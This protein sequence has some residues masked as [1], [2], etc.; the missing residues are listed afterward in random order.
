MPS[1]LD[2]PT[3]S[4]LVRAMWA[5]IR[6]V[7]VLPLVPVT[8]TTGIRGVIVVGRAPGSA[9]A[10]SAAAA[11]TAASTSG[12]GQGVQSVRDGLTQRSRP[13]AVAPRE[14]DHE[15]VG[16]GGGAYAHREPA[17]AGLAGDGPHQALDRAE[18]EALPEA[19]TGRTG[20]VVRSPMRR[21]R[22]STASSLASLMEDTS[23]V[24]FTAARGK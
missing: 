14:G 8:A 3:T 24:S 7:V 20:R 13:T 12:V 21:A 17:G 22:R 9:A 6:D 11:L 19:R 15:D 23:S 5:T 18:G 4:P 2:Q 16:V 10:T 1:V